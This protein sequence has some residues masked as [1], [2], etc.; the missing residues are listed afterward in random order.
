MSV[1]AIA[2]WGANFVVTVSFLT[3]LAAVG[4]AG[5]FFLFGALTM[6]ALVYFHRKVPET[7]NRTLPEIERDLGLPATAKNVSGRPAG[8]KPGSAVPHR[9]N[10][11]T[12]IHEGDEGNADQ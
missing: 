3:L 4:D 5:T 8:E 2:N 9:G 10:P 11:T 1:A 12:T 7:K 6:A